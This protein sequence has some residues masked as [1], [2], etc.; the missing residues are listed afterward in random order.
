MSRCL[1]GHCLFLAEG[2][3]IRTEDII[4]KQKACRGEKR[5]RGRV[6]I[7]LPVTEFSW[8]SFRAVFSRFCCASLQN[9]N[10]E[11]ATYKQQ[12]NSRNQ[13][14][15]LRMNP[16]RIQRTMLWTV[17]QI[18]CLWQSYIL[19]PSQLHWMRFLIHLRLNLNI[20]YIYIYIRS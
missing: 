3:E 2:K 20:T 5:D 8:V 13:Y 16:T 1:N 17:C 9:M 10:S 12:N 7:F 14:F 6:W 19:Y 18:R 4:K 11:P 15:G